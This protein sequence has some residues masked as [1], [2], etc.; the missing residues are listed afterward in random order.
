M[1]N[2]FVDR[3]FNA[4]KDGAGHAALREVA[5][6]GILS[7]TDHRCHIALGQTENIADRVVLRRAGQEIAA[8]GAAYAL[9][10]AGLTQHG[11]NLLEVFLGE[12]LL[13]SGIL[14]TCDLLRL[15]R[16]FHHQAKC[17]AP[18]CGYFHDNSFQFFFASIS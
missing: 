18:F 3:R 6:D 5:G 9:H 1:V 14:Q 16:K 17:V 4:R 10:K 7:E 12:F 8:L 15:S 2:D 11:H 13:C